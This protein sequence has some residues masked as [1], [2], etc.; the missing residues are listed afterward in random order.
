[1]RYHHFLFHFNLS[2][3][4]AFSPI[5]VPIV[6]LP[7]S[8]VLL[9]PL[10]V[11]LSFTSWALSSGLGPFLIFSFIFLIGSVVLHAVP[12]CSSTSTVSCFPV[13][14]CWHTWHGTVCFWFESALPFWIDLLWH[15]Q[16]RH[17]S[18]LHFCCMAATPVSSASL[19]VEFIVGPFY[20]Q[21]RSE[22]GRVV[23][24]QPVFITCLTVLCAASTICF[25]VSSTGISW[26]LFYPFG[27]N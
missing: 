6:G 24:E 2:L 11:V 13:L 26:P 17:A 9:L 22:P 4:T 25:M 21:L 5:Q 18:K 7:L 1:M 14:R 3:T 27:A 16:L 20:S 12:G 23:Y 15:S 19:Q 10:S 8:R